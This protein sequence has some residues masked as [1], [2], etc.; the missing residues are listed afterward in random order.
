MG[1][2]TSQG[3]GAIHPELMKSSVDGSVEWAKEEQQ[4]C[5]WRPNQ[6]QLWGSV[7]ELE[8]CLKGN[9]E[10]LKDPTAAVRRVDWA[11]RA[12]RGTRRLL[13]VHDPSLGKGAW[14]LS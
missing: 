9:R 5:R 7:Q 1:V 2:R 12:W 3:E 4:R 13:H 11:T 14:S 6:G 8:S 10:F